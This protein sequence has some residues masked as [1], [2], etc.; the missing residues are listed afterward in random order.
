MDR[1]WHVNAASQWL[2]VNSLK[3]TVW[4]ER[5]K[6]PKYDENLRDAFYHEPIAFF[7]HLIRENK[8]IS[9]LVAADYSLINQRLAS[10]YGVPG[11]EGADYRKVASATQSGGS[12]INLTIS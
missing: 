8:P 1:R 4:P 9:E 10:W 12:F 11:V 2:K 6:F 7:A 5:G 3:T